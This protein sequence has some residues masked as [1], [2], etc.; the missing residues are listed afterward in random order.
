MLRYFIASH[1]WLLL[2]MSLVLGGG[3]A[4]YNPNFYNVFGLGFIDPKT[5]W[6]TVGLCFAIAV[7]NWTKHQQSLR[8]SRSLK[9]AE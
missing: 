2:G 1:F 5:Y 4:R 3:Y 8:V 7:T 6:I 9:S